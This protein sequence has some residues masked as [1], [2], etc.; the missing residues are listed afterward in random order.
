M[1][2]ALLCSH[3]VTHTAALLSFPFSLHTSP[4]SKDHL[5]HPLHLP[6][7]H[8]PFKLFLSYSQAPAARLSRAKHLQQQ[9]G[10][11]GAG[12]T[13]VQAQSPFILVGGREMPTLYQPYCEAHSRCYWT[14]RAESQLS[15]PSRVFLPLLS[16]HKETQCNGG[17]FLSWWWW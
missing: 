5:H 12:S 9:G 15:F 10:F 17:L 3:R 16:K 13:T 2:Y 4:S 14:N 8:V 11:Q 7:Q 6:T 1:S